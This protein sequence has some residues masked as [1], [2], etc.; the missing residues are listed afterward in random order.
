MRLAPSSTTSRRVLDVVVGQFRNVDQTFDSVEDLDER[1]EGDDLG[2]RAFEH[3]AGAVSADHA[4]PRIFLGLLET[5]RD[6]LAVAVD[7]EHLDL[8]RVANRHHLGRM[9]D[10]APGKLGDVDESVDAFEVHES[11]EIDDVRDL[12]FDH[13]ARLEPVEDLVADFLALLFED[14]AAGKHDVVAAAV[15]LDDLAF[16]RRRHELVE[17]VDPADVDQRSGQE[18]TDAEVEDQTA[19]DDLDHV[20]FDRLAVFGGSLDLAPGLLEAGTLLGKDQATFGVFLGDDERVDFLAELDLFRGIDVLANRELAGGNYTF[21]L[22][23]DV[24]QNLV[25][26]DADDFAVDNVAFLERN[27]GRCVVRNDP[28]INLDE[29]AI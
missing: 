6:A 16:E 23:A 5:Q 25:T 17:V 1:T 3:V 18:A 21:G 7:V 26:V 28:A 4:L 24:E 9:V 8:D 29:Q 14:G 20:A 2:D 15:E 27:D 22:V 10:V 19:L 12:A 11:A 13:F